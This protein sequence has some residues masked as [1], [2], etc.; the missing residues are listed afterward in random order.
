MLNTWGR[1]SWEVGLLTTTIGEIDMSNE[2]ERHIGFKL[3]EKMR[4]ALEV[5][6]FEHDRT[7]SGEIRHLIKEALGVRS[8][9]DY[10]DYL[11]RYQ[12]LKERHPDKFD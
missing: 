4:R 5:V 8:D 10:R 9:L 12:K 11:K 1:S 3:T 7:L 6:A 2:K